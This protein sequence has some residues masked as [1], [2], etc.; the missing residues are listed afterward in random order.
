[1]WRERS[2]AHVG[3]GL[4]EALPLWEPP[5]K[6]GRPSGA[7]ELRCPPVCGAPPVL[8]PNPPKSVVSEHVEQGH[9]RPSSKRL[10]PAP[11]NPILPAP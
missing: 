3:R 5:R 9:T 1:M 8:L 2:L 4:G 7:S 11:P 10:H 6:Q